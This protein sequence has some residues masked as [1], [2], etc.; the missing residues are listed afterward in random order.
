L[1]GVVFER[2]R[3][4]GEVMMVETPAVGAGKEGETGKVGGD[5]RVPQMG[6]ERAGGHP[7]AMLIGMVD[8]VGKD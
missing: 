8:G 2:T 7:G 5:E 4:V 1:R 3:E 6:I